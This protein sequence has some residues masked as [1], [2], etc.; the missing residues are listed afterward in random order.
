MLNKAPEKA[1]KQ[2]PKKEKVPQAKPE[3]KNLLADDAA[4]AKG[5]KPAKE[6]KAKPEPVAKVTSDA[7]GKF[8]IKDIPAGDYVLAVNL[9]AIG[10]AKQ[11]VS[12]TEGGTATVNLTLAPK[13]AAEK[14]PGAEKQPKKKAAEDQ[15]KKAK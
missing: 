8:S 4:K 15:P 13:K 5:D 3:A 7:E 11:K 9:K 12:V 1:Q 14:Q 6:A 10:N 2:N